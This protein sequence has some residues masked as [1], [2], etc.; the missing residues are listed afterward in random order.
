[1]SRRALMSSHPCGG[2]GSPGQVLPHAYTRC[3]MGIVLALLGLDAAP[4]GV[5]VSGFTSRADSHAHAYSELDDHVGTP[6]VDG[7]LAEAVLSALAAALTPVAIAV[8]STL[9]RVHG[10][11]VREHTGAVLRLLEV[12]S[13]PPAPRPS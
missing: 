13:P 3:I 2:A 9:C 10:P 1:M 7:E 5:E 12:R 8:W 11:F 6:L 4:Y